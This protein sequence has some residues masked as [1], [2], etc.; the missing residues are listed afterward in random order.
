MNMSYCRFHNTRLAFNDCKGVLLNPFDEEDGL[1]KDEKQAAIDLLASA[2]EL[3]QDVGSELGV[4]LDDLSD[5]DIINYIELTNGKMGAEEEE[6][7]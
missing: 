2:L 1:S 5:Q 6:P 4:S 3:F 7:D